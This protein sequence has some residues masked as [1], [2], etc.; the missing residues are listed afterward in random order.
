MVLLKALLANDLNISYQR[1]NVASD[2]SI[3][4]R[5]LATESTRQM[6][7][8]ANRADLE[9]YHFVVNEL[10]PCYQRAYG[11][12]LGIDV[13]D[14]L[15]NRQANFNHWKLNLS[16]IKQYVLYRPLLFL[17]RKGMGVV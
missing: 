9:L 8:E 10:Y 15:H 13:S 14:Y 2:N 11:P 12:T 3:K 17:S 4:E 7:I 16:R 5:L 6:L 1:V